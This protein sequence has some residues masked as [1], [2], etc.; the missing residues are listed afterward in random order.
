ML[1]CYLPFLDARVFECETKSLVKYGFD[2]TII[3]PRKGGF[4]LNI[5]GKPI[6]DRFREKTFH[7]QG[8]K[9]VTYDSE[10]RAAD[11]FSDPLYQLGIKEEADFYHAHE[12]NSFSYGR[13]IKIALNRKKGKN[14]KLIY[15]SRQLI[16]D[17][18]S[19][20]IDEKTREKWM[21]MLLEN[22]KEADYI[23]TV[24][25]SIKAWYLSIDPLLQVE[26]IYNSPP[27]AANYNVKGSGDY[28]QR[29]VVA[30]EGNI[31]KESSEKILSATESCSKIMDILLKFIGGPRYG[32]SILIPNDIQASVN[33]SGWVNYLDIP[34]MMSDVDI[35]IIDLD[36]TQSL[37]NT[38]AM[39][40]KLFSYLN[41]GV[42][43]LVSKCSDM[44]KF[45]NTYQCGIVIN[46]SNPASSDYVKGIL[47]LYRNKPQLKQ[48][49]LNA[50][51]AMEDVYCWN[52]MEKRLIKV[53]QSLVSNQTKYLLS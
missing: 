40:S 5:D 33:L 12:L 20:N 19:V 45:V 13:E 4:L 27:L 38:F 25:D 15:D 9:I 28:R 8:V 39:P 26:V 30:H 22:V 7:H 3:A 6:T 35:G 53:Y 32:E 44:E 43:V 14:V 31:T 24:S 23:I 52:H 41:N 16:P 29:F 48:M 47:Y 1:L 49:S 34:G 46:K 42:P 2:V 37:N 11:P 10:K 36:S 50:R 51:K 17:P 21:K 18:L